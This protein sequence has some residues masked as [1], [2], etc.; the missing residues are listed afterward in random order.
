[1]LIRSQD[2]KCITSDL[3]IRYLENEYTNMFDVY[4]D[5]YVL[6]E[7]STEGK[8]FKVLDLICDFYT[9]HLEEITNDKE[10]FVRSVFYMPQDDEVSI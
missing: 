7:Y 1:M 2:K 9:E 10:P 5:T 4:N 8:A 6:G 3:S